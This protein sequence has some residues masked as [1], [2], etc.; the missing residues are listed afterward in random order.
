MITKFHAKL[1][2]HELTRQRS[3]ADLET[4]LAPYLTSASIS[5]RI[6]SRKRCL[7]SKRRYR[8]AWLYG[9]MNIR[10]QRICGIPAIA[11]RNLLRAF[12]NLPTPV[13]VKKGKLTHQPNVLTDQFVADTLRVS[14]GRAA[15]LKQCLKRKALLDSSN[16][17]TEAAGSVRLASA[18]KKIKRETAERIL[19][20]VLEVA[21]KLNKNL[22]PEA[23]IA[24]ID[25]FGSYLGSADRLSD[26]DLMVSFFPPGPDYTQEDDMARQQVGKALRVSR[27]VSL[28][29]LN[30]MSP[31]REEN[32]KRFSEISAA[33]R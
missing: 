23:R 2:A 3:F 25:V 27:Y 14:R 7:R 4:G 20:E 15:Q 8:K 21:K 32:A 22:P 6:S 13:L 18:M 12:N 5:T 30:S 11:V 10:G 17:P 28:S 31:L 16:K 29:T 1:F 19:A 26:L 33:S 24:S 9:R